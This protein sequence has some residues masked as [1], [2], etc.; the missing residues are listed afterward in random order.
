MELALSKPSTPPNNY[1]NLYIHSQSG[2]F[3]KD[4]ILTLTILI[5]FCSKEQISMSEEIWTVEKKKNK[6]YTTKK[7]NKHIHKRVK[8]GIYSVEGTTSFI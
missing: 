4:R 1:C 2:L 8:M 3:L 6:V 7:K 5:Q